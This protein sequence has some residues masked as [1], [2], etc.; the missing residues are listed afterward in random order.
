MQP[1]DNDQRSEEGNTDGGR[2]PERGSPLYPI[3]VAFSEMADRLNRPVPI[4]EAGKPFNLSATIGGEG[5][6]N[7]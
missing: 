1:H 5:S 2:Y 7:G 6:V 4:A 3:W